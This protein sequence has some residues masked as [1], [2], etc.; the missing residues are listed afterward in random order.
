MRAW[1]GAIWTLRRGP[2]LLLGQLAATAAALAW[3]PGNPA[4]LATMVAIWWVG[5]G[6]LTG[7]EFLAACAVDSAFVVMNRAA[8]DQGLFRFD[9]PDLFGMPYYEYLAWGFYT[10]HAIRLIGG[11]PANGNLYFAAGAAAVFALPFA[12]IADRSALLPA[13][14]ILLA[15]CLALFHE[16]NDVLYAGYM[17][18]LGVLIEHVG[19]STGQWQYPDPPWGG[20]PLWSLTMW[21]GVGLFTR[22]LILPAIHRTGRPRG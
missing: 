14:A 1:V 4:K 15:S 7:A 19:V 20:V 17:A 6:R 9:H 2:L 21:A 3:V 16:F 10:L 22:R 11:R 13:S 8:L 5:F 12:T 18:G